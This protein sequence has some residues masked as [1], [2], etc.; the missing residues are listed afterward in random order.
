MWTQDGIRVY[1]KTFLLTPH[2]CQH[3]MKQP[4]N[5]PTGCA[6]LCSRLATTYVMHKTDKQNITTVDAAP[7]SSILET[8][9]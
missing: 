9:S 8:K 3:P 2:G 1:P 5:S 6:T 7:R 4:T